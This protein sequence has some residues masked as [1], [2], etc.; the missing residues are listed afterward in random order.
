MA[1]YQPH[2][3]R[4]RNLAGL[5]KNLRLGDDG[6]DFPDDIDAPTR[7]LLVAADREHLTALE[8]A[9]AAIGLR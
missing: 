5:E 4:S 2:R 1:A 9:F 6:R 3:K 7:A 8:A